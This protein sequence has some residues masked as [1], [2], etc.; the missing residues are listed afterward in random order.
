MFQHI[1]TFSVCLWSLSLF[2]TS[3]Q[4]MT[5]YY[6]VGRLKAY[7]IMHQL[8]SNTVPTALIFLRMCVCDESRSSPT[9][10]VWSWRRRRRKPFISVGR[11]SHCPTEHTCTPVRLSAAFSCFSLWLQDETVLKAWSVLFFPAG[12]SGSA[13]KSPSHSGS[14]LT[15]VSVYM[16]LHWCRL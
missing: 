6:N 4:F 3:P 14:G 7:R 9:W 1:H 5:I 11:H 2:V 10:A 13:S 12:L 16:R 8:H 15:R